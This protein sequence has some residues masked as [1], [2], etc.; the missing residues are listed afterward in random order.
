MKTPSNGIVCPMFAMNKTTTKG[1][2]GIIYSMDELAVTFTGY[3]DARRNRD[4]F[5][6]RDDGYYEATQCLR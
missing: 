2:G 3:G 1:G 4:P 6:S 5:S